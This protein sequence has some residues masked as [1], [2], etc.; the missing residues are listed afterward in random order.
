SELITLI[1]NN[2]TSGIYHPQN[3]K[4]VKTSTLVQMIATLNNNRI[5]FLKFGNPLIKR[6][7]KINIIR[8]VFGDLYYTSTLSNHFEG[9]YQVVDF[10]KSIEATERNT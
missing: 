7:L 2:Q 1:I 4:L 9:T 3:K 10:E 5:K 8:K 6:L